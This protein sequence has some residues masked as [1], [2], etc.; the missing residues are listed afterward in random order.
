MQLVDEVIRTQLHSEVV[1]V[2]QVAN[3]I[4]QSGGKRLRPA[5]LLM[6]S[7]ALGADTAHRH[8]LA[9]VVEFIHT[10]TLLHDDV[11]DESTMR[12]G[13]DTA[14][15]LFGNAASV[16]VGDFLYSRAFQMMVDAG[17]MRIMQVLSDATNVIAEGEVLQLMNM[18]DA[19]LSRDG[20]LHVI[21][22]KTAKLFEASTRI[23][24]ILNQQDEQTEAACAE[25][26]E[27]LGTAF[28]I[29]DDVLDYE[30]QAQELGKNLGDDLREGKLTL[31]V[32]C[33]LEQVSGAEHD[34]IVS[35]I[36]NGD[37]SQLE[38]IKQLIHQHGGLVQARE[39]AQLEAQRAMAAIQRLPDNGYTQSL[40]ALAASLVHRRT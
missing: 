1:L 7:G 35:A 11:V 6:M 31:P 2:S 34:L 30:G 21:R 24:A 38:R 40:N 18:H 17:S 22:S 26:G 19:T 29:I 12:R 36:E 28:Q 16:L 13:R 8:S 27:A 15:E 37:L 5:L 33:T 39:V 32:I 14:N 25:Y 10:A 3:Y 20:Y 9:A 4:I 23:A